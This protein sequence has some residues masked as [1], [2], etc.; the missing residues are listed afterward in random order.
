MHIAMAVGSM[1][2]HQFFMVH[3]PLD[4]LR[5]YPWEVDMIKNHDPTRCL[6]HQL[7]LSIH[8]PCPCLQ[9]S[10]GLRP[11][12]F[13]ASIYRREEEILKEAGIE[14]TGIID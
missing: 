13:C 5:H 4:F 10:T 2:L 6:S 1:E 11:D 3:V 9:L 12:V 7:E 8:F 14:V